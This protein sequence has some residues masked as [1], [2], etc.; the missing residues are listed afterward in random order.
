MII[1]IGGADN[2]NSHSVLN[3]IITQQNIKEVCIVTS[4]TKYVLEAFN[5]YKRI[6]EKYSCN[7]TNISNPDLE[8]AK[9]SIFKCDMVFMT[10]GDQRKLVDKLKETEFLK[11][12]KD[13]YKKKNI[14]LAGTSAGAMAFSKYM[15]I[16]DFEISNGLNF[17]KLTIDTHFS[18]RKRLS[19]LISF[20]IDANIEKGIGIDEDTCVI[21]KEY[22]IENT[23]F[24][25][26]DIRG[27]GSCF[28]INKSQNTITI[29]IH[30][31][32]EIKV[33]TI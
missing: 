29:N 24:K 1:L 30:K 14:V 13:R 2:K 9:E 27:S 20:M 16:N 32:E 12:M 10:G 25:S 21:I 28:L 4:A 31:N 23:L 33:N 17:I 8:S 5:K 15:I 19:R 3:N 6:F 18:E 7:V 11:I 22:F 26:F